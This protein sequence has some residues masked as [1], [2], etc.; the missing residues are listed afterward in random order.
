MLLAHVEPCYMEAIE[1]EAV[2]LFRHNS[3]GC[4]SPEHSRRVPKGDF[5]NNINNGIELLSPKSHQRIDITN[6]KANSSFLSHL[7][8]KMECPECG[9]RLY[10]HNFSAHYRIHTGE[11]P[12][13]YVIQGKPYCC[14]QCPYAC[15]TKRNLDRHVYNNHTKDTSRR[16]ITTFPRT[17]KG[18][19]DGSE[20]T[21]LFNSP[22]Q[23]SLGHFN[24]AYTSN[25][26]N[27]EDVIVRCEPKHLS[28]SYVYFSMF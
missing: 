23:Q 8:T 12:Y 20:G 13:P 17:R 26:D 1:Y 15:I 25:E 19:Y 14:P 18:R 6:A 10:R 24:G 4:A 7:D 3:N 22:K 2:M 11:L 16:K 5:S 9:L 27:M 21:H 28:G